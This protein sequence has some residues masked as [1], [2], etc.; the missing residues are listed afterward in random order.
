MQNRI[1]DHLVESLQDAVFL[2]RKPE[3]HLHYANRAA[4]ELFGYSRQEL[5]GSSTELLHVDRAHYE[6]FHEMTAPVVM[7]EHKTFQGRFRMKRKSGEVFS[8]A[9]SVTLF[10]DDDGQTYVVSVVRDI[11]IEEQQ[12]QRIQQSESLLSMIADNLR[13]VIWVSNSDKT[14]VEYVSPA[15]EKHWGHRVDDLY[16]DPMAIARVIHPDDRLNVGAQIVQ[17]ALEPHDVQYRIVRPDG[18]IRWIWDRTVPIRDDSGQVTRILGI[19]E[20]I[21]DLKRHEAEMLHAQKMEAVGRLTGGI[22]HDFNNMLT[23]I[24]GNAEMLLQDLADRPDSQVLAQSLYK[25]SQRAA[26]LTSRLMAFARQQPVQRDRMEMNQLIEDLLQLLRQSLGED[27]QII[28]RLADDTWAVAADRSQLEASLMNLV[29]NARDAMPQGGQLTISTRNVRRR[30][31]PAPGKVS[32]QLPSQSADAD[33]STSTDW[34]EIQIQDTGTGI[35]PDIINKIFE[36]FFTTKGPGQGTGMGLSMV[37]GFVND[38]GGHIEV[39]ST[40]GQGSTFRLHLTRHIEESDQPVRAEPE[41]LPG[42]E[43]LLLVEDEALV[44][45]LLAVQLR[46]LGYQVSEAADGPEALRVFQAQPDIAMLVSDV[47][48]P[49]GLSGPALASQLRTLHP[50]LPVL[51]ISGHGA[52]AALANAGLPDDTP[53]LHKPFPI[54]DLTRKIRALL[55]Q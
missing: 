34:V 32:T 42:T 16:A 2:V 49:G 50:N 8:S 19:A 47:I 30:G 15:Y 22:A 3:R 31:P 36:P 25:A 12:A 37:F 40:P 13:E 48:M 14:Q 45:A 20:D 35:T 54:R 52:E 55:D 24:M 23:V 6:A 29:V 44:R 17:Q 28:T 21:T 9:H 27:I 38:A 18:E 10:A 46:D 7:G 43:H 5:I 53:V 51:F 1:F 39:D 33:P 11:S 4:V 41:S 26:D